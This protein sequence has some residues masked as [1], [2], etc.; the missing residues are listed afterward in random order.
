M[1]LID[2][3]PSRALKAALCPPA[4]ERIRPAFAGFSPFV[5]VISALTLAS[6]RV[7]NLHNL[8]QLP[9]HL[10]RDIGLEDSDIVQLKPTAFNSDSTDPQIQRLR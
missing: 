3:Q 5:W 6:A 4:F 7:R 10:L 8:R 9:D 1:T 2:S